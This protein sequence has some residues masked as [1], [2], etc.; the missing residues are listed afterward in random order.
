MKKNWLASALISTGLVI[1]GLGMISNAVAFSENSLPDMVLVK[2]GSFMQGTDEQDAAHNKRTSPLHQVKVSDFY[3]SSHEVTVEQFAYFVQQT[4]Y[5]TDAERNARVGTNEAKGCFVRSIA[6]Q[7]DAGWREG[8]SWKNPGFGQQ[9]THPVVC[10][11]WDDAQAY[12]SWLST[13]IGKNF[14]LPTESEFEYAQRA[15]STRATFLTDK[16]NA[17]EFFNFA[18]QSQQHAYGLEGQTAAL[19]D[20]GYVTTSPVGK[21]AA[22][23]IGLFD[24]DSNVLEWVED[25]W[26]GNYQGAPSDGSARQAPEGKTCKFRALRGNDFMS[27]LNK[28]TAAHRSSI[29]HAFRVYHVGFRV[30]LSNNSNN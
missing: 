19:C 28:V 9:P 13:A 20:D 23:P 2:G 3:L 10:V 16:D 14:R 5:V 27:P 1:S 7:N 25:C 30:A 22:N 4:G 26:F 12:V 29:P 8:T 18:D 17:C 21:F 15:G 24:M 11:S 6:K